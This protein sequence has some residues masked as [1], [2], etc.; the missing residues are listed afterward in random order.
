MEGI[1]IVEP[2]RYH[3]LCLIPISHHDMVDLMVEI[4]NDVNSSKIL[5]VPLKIFIEIE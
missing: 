3:F 1:P 5:I 4:F 2:S